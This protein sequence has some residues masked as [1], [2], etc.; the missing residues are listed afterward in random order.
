MCLSTSLHHPNVKKQSSV[1]ELY[2]GSNDI[3][4]RSKISAR[5]PI[6]WKINENEAIIRWIWLTKKI[7]TVV[8]YWPSTEP[9]IKRQVHPVE[10]VTLTCGRIE[11]GTD[12]MP[13]RSKRMSNNYITRCHRRLELVGVSCSRSSSCSS[14]QWEP[15]PD[16][17]LAALRTPGWA[18]Q[19]NKKEVLL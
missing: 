17:G 13:T 12:A 3:L 18:A 5:C 10:D 7:A 4:S 16:R 14:R 2:P 9:S 1:L 19:Q 6:Q 8:T 11:F 15:A